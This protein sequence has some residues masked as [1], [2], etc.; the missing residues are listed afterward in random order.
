MLPPFL[1]LGFRQ[2]IMFAWSSQATADRTG[3]KLNIKKE[4][5]APVLNTMEKTVYRYVPVRVIDAT[6]N[7]SE[8]KPKLPNTTNHL[9]VSWND[10]S[11]RL[12]L[13]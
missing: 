1:D 12:R 8:G 11:D 6:P 4:A 7:H 3:G 10:C 5:K 9:A 13:I 2:D